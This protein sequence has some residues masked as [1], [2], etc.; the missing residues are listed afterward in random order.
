MNSRVIDD[1][2]VNMV[3]VGEERANRHD[4][5]QGGRQPTTKKFTVLT[6]AW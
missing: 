2:T 4:A 5:L 3:D 6:E 1:L